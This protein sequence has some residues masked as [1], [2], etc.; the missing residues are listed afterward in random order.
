MRFLDLF[1]NFS[2]FIACRKKPMIRGGIIKR[3]SYKQVVP[4]K[5]L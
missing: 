5:C 2:N 3:P 4:L 1:E